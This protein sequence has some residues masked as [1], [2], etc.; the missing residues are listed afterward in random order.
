MQDYKVLKRYDSSWQSNVLLV[1]NKLTGE[2]FVR[3]EV[4]SE[5]SLMNTVELDI[6]Q[7]IKHP[8]IIESL[9]C[10]YTLN[11][12]YKNKRKKKGQKTYVRNLFFLFPLANSTLEDVILASTKGKQQLSYNQRMKYLQDIASGLLFL[13]KNGIYH[14]DLKP[15]NILIF[16]NRAV[17]ADL[18]C[19][20]Y[21]ETVKV[22]FCH[23]LMWTPPETLLTIQD[24]VDYFEIMRQARFVSE[25]ILDP[26][27]ADIWAFAL[28]CLAVLLERYHYRAEKTHEENYLSFLKNKDSIIEETDKKFHIMLKS[29]LETRPSLRC[30]SL[31]LFFETLECEPSSGSI[32]KSLDFDE[33]DEELFEKHEDEIEELL[34]FIFEIYKNVG[35]KPVTYYYVVDLF[36]RSLPLIFREDEINDELIN[37]EIKNILGSDFN[38]VIDGILNEHRETKE[39]DLEDN[40]EK[41]KK[42]TIN[43]LKRLAVSCLVL[44]SVSLDE[45]FNDIIKDLQP[46][47]KI[48]DEK[49]IY[50]ISQITMFN[51]GI[52]LLPSF[53]SFASDD[54]LSYK[55]Y[56]EMKRRI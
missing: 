22:K 18:G 30:S 14:C 21:K 9:S 53:L 50:I 5:Y 1:E 3:K 36:I 27:K 25:P 26:Q 31:N 56:I 4:F 35:L 41:K 15:N 29:M 54:Y 11:K 44:C 13:H 7:R 43:K 46:F 23:T 48:S 8:N 45:E 16:G 28:L 55:N 40:K 47:F 2:R 33:R 49:I 20:V 51:K 12:V 19:A 37:D 52:L 17:I 24:D 6:M 34:R 38:D 42:D 10:S 39:I 32:V